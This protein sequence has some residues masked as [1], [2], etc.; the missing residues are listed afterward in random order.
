MGG[1]R[2][3]LHLMQRTA[4]QGSPDM[5]TAITGRWT[6]G[7]Q[8][9]ED[10][11]HP[12]RKS[13]AE[14]RIGDTISSAPRRVSLLTLTSAARAAAPSGWQLQAS[15]DG[16][17]WRTLDTRQQQRFA[18]P[19]QTRAFAVQ[20]PGEYAYYRVHFDAAPSASIRALA[21]IEL[22]GPAP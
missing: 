1:L 3:V 10:G 22:L 14:L 15:V 20:A 18:W 5:L 4:L 17:H 2:G 16:H 11:V 19:R 21:E 9:V 13:L 8:R 12:F 7:S 6:K